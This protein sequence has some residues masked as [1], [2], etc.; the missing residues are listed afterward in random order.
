M[1]NRW[2]IFFTDTKYQK[3]LSGLLILNAEKVLKTAYSYGV[4]S[5]NELELKTSD[6]KVKLSEDLTDLLEILYGKCFNT[7]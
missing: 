1:Q 6:L 4:I 3:L 5:K 7:S 2:R